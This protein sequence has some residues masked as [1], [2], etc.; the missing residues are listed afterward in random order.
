[1]IWPPQQDAAL[2]KASHWFKHLSREQQIFRLFGYAGTLK[3]TLATHLDQD[4]TGGQSQFM[5][6]TGKAASVLQSKGCANADTIHSQIYN[7]KDKSKQR[8]RDLEALKAKLFADKENGRINAKLADS[9]MYK[10]DRMIE[11][12]MTQ[13]R[14]PMWSVNLL[15]AIKDRPLLIVDECSMVG[16]R[17][18]MDL[19]SFN[20]PILVLGD[21]A[22]LPPVMGGGYFTNHKPD[23]MLT[24]VHRQAKDSPIIYLATTVREGGSLK[25]GTYG[26]C[27]VLPRS[28]LTA[29]M[30]MNTDQLLVGRNNTRRA[31][32]W[33]IRQLLKRESS[34]PLK[35]D[36]LVCLRN[37]R[38]MGILN[39]VQ[40]VCQEDA[41]DMQDGSVFLHLV[42][43]D[44]KNEHPHI[45]SLSAHQAVFL[46]EEVPFYEA[47]DHESFDFGNALTVHKAQGSQWN[48]VTLFDE[49]HQRDSRQQWLYT[50]ITRAA[51]LLEVVQF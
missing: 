11:E 22:Q 46:G 18:A 32:N 38:E 8:L 16:E 42:N 31:S 28:A 40:Y 39:G 37:N 51:E 35:D 50:G 6:F 19:L 29:E 27:K 12:E 17:E 2:K 21:P 7:A 30:V 4:L 47:K 20:I 43:S 34:F 5:T 49:W 24:D 44:D 23:V 48:H 33:R 3:T 25:P 26:Q 9:E 10:I 36:L 14:R 41:S 45:Y 15:S 13:L 1:M